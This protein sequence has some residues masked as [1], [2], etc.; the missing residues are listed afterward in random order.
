M[1]IQ[2]EKD[3]LWEML[4]TLNYQLVDVQEQISNAEF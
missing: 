1:Q 2:P 4:D 3:K